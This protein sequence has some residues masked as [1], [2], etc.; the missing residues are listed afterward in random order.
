MV[1]AKKGGRIAF[2]LSSVSFSA[3]SKALFS[4]FAASIVVLNLSHVYRRVT[5]VDE[6]VSE[7]KRRLDLPLRFPQDTTRRLFRNEEGETE[8]TFSL[9]P[10]PAAEEGDGDDDDRMWVEVMSWSPRAF[11][12]HNVLSHEQCDGMIK[13]SLPSME[14]ALV[15]GGDVTEW[16]TNTQRWV[17][18][19]ESRKDKNFRRLIKQAALIS[20]YPEVN[21]ELVQI[22]RYQSGEYYMPHYDS[23]KNIQDLQGQAQRV[24]TILFYLSDVDKGV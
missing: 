9:K 8:I 22:L 4:L 7:R 24:M 11:V 2:A 13:A 3:Y 1:K 14:S 21:Q 23:L 10:P 15:E 20:G 17:R 18:L 19:E 5:Q 12:L 16:R 6:K